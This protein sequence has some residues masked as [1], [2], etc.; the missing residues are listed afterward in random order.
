MN[1]EYSEFV[2]NQLSKSLF[3][4]YLLQTTSGHTDTGFEE[5]NQACSKKSTQLLLQNRVEHVPKFNYASGDTLTLTETEIDMDFPGFSSFVLIS[6]L[7]RWGRLAG[8]QIQI[9]VFHLLVSLWLHHRTTPTI[10]S[11]GCTQLHVLH[12]PGRDVF[13]WEKR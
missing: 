9:K 11:H 13:Y 7:S 3:L 2:K 8:V 12:S 4:S 1:S 6:Y 10:C 5:R